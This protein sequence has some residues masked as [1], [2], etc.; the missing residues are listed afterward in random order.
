VAE[1]VVG[2]GVLSISTPL[3]KTNP[4]DVKSAHKKKKES[5]KTEF[6]AEQRKYV[7]KRDFK[8]LF[9]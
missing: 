8:L 2:D 5:N 3:C 6:I 9:C 7:K 1:G 4:T